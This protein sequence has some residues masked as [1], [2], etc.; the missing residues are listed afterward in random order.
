MGVD[1]RFVAI[2]INTFSSLNVFVVIALAGLLM[3]CLE[4]FHGI[5]R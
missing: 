4:F 1:A 3:P 5:S 2:F